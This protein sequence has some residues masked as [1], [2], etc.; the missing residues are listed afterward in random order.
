[1]KATMQQI[2]EINFTCDDCII[3]TPLCA[4]K[5]DLPFKLPTSDVNYLNSQALFV[6]YNADDRR[7]FNLFF[8]RRLALGW[9][10]RLPTSGVTYP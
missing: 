3:A 4:A 2:A 5:I 10:H 7:G 9:H 6:L 1:M 8:A